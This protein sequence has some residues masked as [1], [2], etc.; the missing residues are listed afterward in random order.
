[1][2]EVVLTVVGLVATAAMAMIRIVRMV[3]VLVS[4][5]VV[6]VV[7]RIAITISGNHTILSTNCSLHVGL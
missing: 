1:M 5:V 3:L 4:E 7:L 6:A 2:V